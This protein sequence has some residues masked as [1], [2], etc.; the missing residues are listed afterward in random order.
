[1]IHLSEAAPL[2]IVEPEHVRLDAE[3]AEHRGAARKRE[4]VS[5]RSCATCRADVG[6]DQSGGISID[7][8]VDRL[9]L[10]CVVESLV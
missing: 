2:D 8:D 4:R 7:D 3:M 9:A 6:T 10:Q 1:M 5:G